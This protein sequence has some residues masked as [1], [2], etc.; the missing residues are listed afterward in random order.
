VLKTMWNMP[1]ELLRTSVAND[2]AEHI[3]ERL[4]SGSLGQMIEAF[5][6]HDDP[7]ADAIV[8][9]CAG[10]D[11]TITSQEIRDLRR[12]LITAKAA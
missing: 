10:R 2:G 8:I 11:R 12:D 6:E 9:K 3:D 7:D 1:A 4:A 5:D